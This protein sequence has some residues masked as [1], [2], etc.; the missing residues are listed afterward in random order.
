MPIDPSYARIADEGAIEDAVIPQ[1]VEDT[2]K[3]I[4]GEK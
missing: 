3:T 1:A 2:L 4:L